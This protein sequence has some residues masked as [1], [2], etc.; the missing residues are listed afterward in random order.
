[1]KNNKKKKKD[2]NNYESEDYRDLVRKDG[3]KKSKR[4]STRKQQKQDLK[5]YMDNSW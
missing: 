3:L 4:R 1:M 2:S 5:F